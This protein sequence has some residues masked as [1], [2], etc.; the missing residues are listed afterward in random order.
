ME[1]SNNKLAGP[2]QIRRPK[3]TQYYTKRNS[4]QLANTYELTNTHMHNNNNTKYGV[5]K[6]K[7]CVAKSSLFNGSYASLFSQRRRC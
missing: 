2:Q 4:K 1:W 3:F 5:L 7:K 6:K